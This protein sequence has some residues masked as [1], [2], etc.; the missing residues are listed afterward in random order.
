ME[1]NRASKQWATRP[2]DQRFLSL[3]DLYSSVKNR[4]ANS[5]FITAQS[6]DITVEAEGDNLIINKNLYPTNWSFS[7]LAN[8]ANAPAYY[9]NKLSASLAAVNI[10]YGLK[11]IPIREDVMLLTHGNEFRA[12]TSDIYGRVWDE[13]VVK[14]VQDLN[15]DNIWKIPTAS[16]FNADPLRAT[17]L[18]ASDRDVFIFLVDPEHPIEVG[19]ETLFKGFFCW[20]SEVG[21]LT[22]GITTFL[23]RYI[24]DNRIVWG[25]TNIQEL[26]LRH[27][28]NAPE[29]FQVEGVKYLEQYANEGTKFLTDPIKKA[30]KF[31]IASTNVEG[32][33]SEEKWE[34]WLRGNK[35]SKKQAQQ[36]VLCAEKEEG[37]AKSLWNIVN[38]ATAYAREIPYTDE[39]VKMESLAGGLLEK[40]G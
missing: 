34:N 26:R 11:N 25:A 16:Y 38:G 27:S 9:L 37:G 32:N 31:E 36:S 13:Q 8:Y 33:T 20:N 14:M 29:R 40:V 23:Y 12:L 15:P 6:A 17:T 4:K 10:N 5:K 2:N 28:K 30:Q 1:L 18:Y 22:F 19:G 7:Q 35:F 24:C 21:Y 39:R 3:D